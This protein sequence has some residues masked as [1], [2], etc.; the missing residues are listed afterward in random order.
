MQRLS[1]RYVDWLQRHG[2][3]VLVATAAVVAASIYLAAFHLPLH[4][5]LS[6]LLPT[7][8]PAIRAGLRRKCVRFERRW[9]E[10]RKCSKPARVGTG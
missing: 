5:D 9:V 8:T 7:E 6:D 10:R 3:A 2:R 4:A 1:M